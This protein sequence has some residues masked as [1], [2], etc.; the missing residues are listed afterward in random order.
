MTT[1]HDAAAEMLNLQG[2]SEYARQLA[3]EALQNGRL[4]FGVRL[5]QLALEAARAAKAARASLPP[6]PDQ[7]PEVPVVAGPL[8]PEWRP[9]VSSMHVTAPGRTCR[10]CG[11]GG[12]V[13]APPEPEPEEEPATAAMVTSRC[14]VDVQQLGSQK[15]LEKCWGAIYHKR[16]TGMWHHVH[17]DMDIHHTPVPYDAGVATPD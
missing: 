7:A 9:C 6:V 8:E 10:V 1:F 5:A 3:I 12:V 11:A 2:D 4:E 17:P 16:E 15:A 13:E 14:N